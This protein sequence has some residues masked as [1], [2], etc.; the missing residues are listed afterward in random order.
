MKTALFGLA[1][2]AAG[3]ACSLPAAAA[4]TE[5]LQI[6]SGTTNPRALSIDGYDPIGQTFTAFTDTVT[7]VGFEFT[8]LNP[9][10]ANES[11]TLNIYAGEALSGVS[12]FTK[13]FQFPA[14]IDVRDERAWYDIAVPGIA[15]VQGQTYSLI[16][17]GQS[18]YR[19]A[20]LT[21]PGYHSPTGT[22]FGGDAYA[23][24]R[25]ISAVTTYPN[26][27]GAGNTCDAN[28]R[29]TGETFA[30]AVPE[31]ASWGLLIPGFGAV[32][33]ALRGT[34]KRRVALKFA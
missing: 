30:A 19:A 18:S 1:A 27:A 11:L 2:C 12:L 16:L 25:L 32:G 28:F 9:Q 31:P 26:C 17:R 34:R 20:L 33:S 23:G 3:L 4:T 14:S 13:T 15:V 24:G 7:S 10:A 6:Q 21:G 8:T 5:A 29:V 22:F